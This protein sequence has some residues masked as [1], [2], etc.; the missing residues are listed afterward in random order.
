LFALILVKLFQSQI[1]SFL[2][3]TLKKHFDTREQL[4]LDQQEHEQAKQLAEMNLLK[5][6]EM[7]QLSSLSF[8]EEQI[9]QL[10]AETQTQLQ[11]ANSFIRQSVSDKLDILIEGQRFI[12]REIRYM[13][14]GKKNP[15]G[16]ATKND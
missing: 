3:D 8:T 4:K 15:N 13:R 10:T 16:D 12:L 14:N 2:P 7:S 9:T 5:L 6:R 11:E 1:V